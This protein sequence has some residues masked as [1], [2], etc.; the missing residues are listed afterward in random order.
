MDTDFVN[1]NS[2]NMNRQI[3]ADISLFA[4]TAVWGSSFIMMKIILTHISTF[5]YLSIRFTLATLILLL[6][7][8]KYLPK[9]NRKA[10]IFGSIIGVTLFAG[11][12]F[13]VAGLTYTEASRSAFIT[14]LSV[15]FVPIV[16]AMLLRKRPDKASVL[17][18]FLAFTGMFFL[19]G[20]IGTF[21][22]GAG[23]NF[24]KGD[25]LTFFCA[26]SFS[27]YIILVDKFTNEVDPRLLAIMQMATA[28]VLCSIVYG[29]TD[30]SPIQ[31]NGTVILVL[32]ITSVF[33]TAV[34]FTVQTIA[35][36][37]TS[38]THTALILAS[39]PVFAL[40]FALIIPNAAGITEK[41][42]LNSVIGCALI[43]GG[44]LISELLPVIIKKRGFA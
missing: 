31:I 37:Y 34:A 41:L 1:A 6:I 17:G 30:K 3:K 36:K 16:S 22:N 32:I 38:P 42:A 26:L 20:G 19:T 8:H 5:A 28:A 2:I 39:E 18:V 44:M 25:L 35:Q 13:Q 43:L 15:V 40:F 33:S 10:I 24:N 9:L 21:A 4:I 27:A 11:M 14:A 23:F 7:F 12:A 29:F